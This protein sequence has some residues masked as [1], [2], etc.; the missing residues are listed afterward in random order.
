MSANPI[1]HQEFA[2][3]IALQ[4]AIKCFWYNRRDVG[5]TPSN[6]EVVPDGY[7]ELIFYF[8]N[9]QY[10]NETI[11]NQLPSPFLMGLLNEPVTFSTKNVLEVLGVRCYPWAVFDMLGLPSGADKI[12][13]FKHEIARLHPKLAVFV[14]Q[15]KIAEAIAVIQQFFETARTG[16]PANSLLYKAGKAMQNTN[17]TLPVKEV[18]SAAH[19]T[20]RTLERQFKQSSGHTVKNVSALMR[21]EQVRNALWHH[22]EQSIATLAYDF[23][24]TDQSHLSK[25]FKKF[26]GTTP[27]AFARNAKKQKLFAHHHFVA[28]VQS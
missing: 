6:F 10:K 7:A 2:P 22:P 27:A 24:Y 18:A 17:G 14:Q 19:A 28:F 1:Y 21:F 11:A 3:P 5:A 4:D 15:Q 16:L 9:L 12:H 25:A 26:S 13:V 23:G 8:G 20:V